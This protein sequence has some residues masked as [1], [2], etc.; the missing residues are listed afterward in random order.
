MQ[1]V[2]DMKGHCQGSYTRCWND[3]ITLDPPWGIKEVMEAKIPRELVVSYKRP[4]QREK[5]KSS[6]DMLGGGLLSMM[7]EGIACCTLF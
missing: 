1:R 5:H 2:G 3:G 7:E 4:R 6:K